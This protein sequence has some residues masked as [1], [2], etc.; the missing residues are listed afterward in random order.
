VLFRSVAPFELASVAV[1]SVAV[2][3]ILPAPESDG[4]TAIPVTDLPCIAAK[5]D[6]WSVALVQPTSTETLAGVR[7][8][9][10]ADLVAR[11]IEEGTRLL[12]AA[13]AELRAWRQAPG[14]HVAADQLRR[15]LHGFKGGARMAGAMRLGQLLQSMESRLATCEHRAAPPELFQA[16]DTDLDFIGYMLERINAGESNVAL[17]RIAPKIT[18]EAKPATR[19][20][21]VPAETEAPAPDA[22]IAPQVPASDDGAIGVLK[23]NVTGMAERLSQVRGQIREI[24]VQTELS[25]RSRMTELT[26]SGGG[27]DSSELDGITRLQDLAHSLAE[28][29]GGLTSAQQSLLR[30]LDDSATAL[31]RQ[32]GLPPGT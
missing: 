25:L 23:A 22:A 2:D 3:P 15:T 9:I 26:E 32:R 14:D 31:P 19:I 11:F 10:D 29:L 6:I 4:P 12:P 1:A 13:R 7:D 8:E 24:E 5:K 27:C 21:P 30:Y 20:E 18:A 28:A 16:L 17:P